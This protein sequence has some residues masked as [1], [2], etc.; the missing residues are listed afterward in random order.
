M[1]AAIETARDLVPL[2]ERC[3]IVAIGP[4][5]GSGEW[6]TAMLD[7]ALSADRPLVV[8]AD[9]LNLLAQR[10]ADGATTGF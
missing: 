4:G 1:T 10:A 8:D 3:S 6:G 9:A 2:L 5:L 7:A